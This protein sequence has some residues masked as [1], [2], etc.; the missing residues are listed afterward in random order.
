MN[1]LFLDLGS[2]TGCIACVQE[3]SVASMQTIGHRT[4]DETLLP[5][6]EETLKEAGWQWSDLTHSACVIGPGGFMSLRVAVAF[7]NTIVHRL[8]I[9]GTGV[10]LSD[11]YCAR[12]NS[13]KSIVQSC[14]WLHST[15]KTQLFIRGFGEFEKHWPE[16]VQISLEEIANPSTAL[17]TGRQSQFANSVW[18][19]ELLPEHAAVLSEMGIEPAPLQSLEEVLPQFLAKKTYD[20]SL[21]EPWYGRE[22]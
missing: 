5:A 18:I 15:K 6:I 4:S 16:P 21:L 8:K 19:G 14:L 17:R 1:I 7:A 3:D 20:S 10:H 12:V 2:S 11:L 22:G 9:P 13:Q